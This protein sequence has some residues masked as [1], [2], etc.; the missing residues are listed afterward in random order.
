MIGDVLSNSNEVLD[1]SLLE[2]ISSDVG[3]F[4]NETIDIVSATFYWEHHII[5]SNIK[6]RTW[7]LQLGWS[8]NSMVSD[9][10][11]IVPDAT[12]DKIF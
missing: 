12:I 11:Q 2:R 10:C 1:V 8:Q 6:T 7:Y 5:T 3:D 4:T 9:D